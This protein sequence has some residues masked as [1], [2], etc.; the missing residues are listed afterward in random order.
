L[1][2]IGRFEELFGTGKGMYFESKNTTAVLRSKHGC[3][4]TVAGIQLK[5]TINY[6]IS[7]QDIKTHSIFKKKSSPLKIK[8]K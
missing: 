3:H 1:K 7:I 8:L 5:P 4:E 2:F 6:W